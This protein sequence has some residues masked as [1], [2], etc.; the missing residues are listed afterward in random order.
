MVQAFY[1][2]TMFFNP[3]GTVRFQSWDEIPERFRHCI[4]GMEVKYYGKD[5]DKR[6]IMLKLVN[7]E[8]AQMQLAKYIQMIKDV[9]AVQVIPL[10]KETEDKL[11]D[12]FRKG[13]KGGK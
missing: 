9:P 3:D 1:D 11:V 4:E 7:R 5:A 8:K 6:V 12:I 2:P 13:V 10:G